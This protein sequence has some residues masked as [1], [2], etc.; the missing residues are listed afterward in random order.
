MNKVLS[1]WDLFLLWSILVVLFGS[2]SGIGLGSLFGV[3]HLI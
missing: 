1:F 2:L 3:V